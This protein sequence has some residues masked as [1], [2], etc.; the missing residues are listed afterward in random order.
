MEGVTQAF[1]KA[2]MGTQQQ[3]LRYQLTMG[4]AWTMMVFRSGILERIPAVQA[5]S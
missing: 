5:Q 3:N 2:K 4:N 1:K